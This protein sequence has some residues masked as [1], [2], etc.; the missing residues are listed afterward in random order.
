M[1]VIELL[2]LVALVSALGILM[3]VMVCCLISLDD[4]GF[5]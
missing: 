3:C 4:E 5:L 1:D 2:K